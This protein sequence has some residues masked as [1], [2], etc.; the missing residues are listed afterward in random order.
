MSDLSGT[1][2]FSFDEFRKYLMHDLESLR[3]I[4]KEIATGGNFDSDLM[5]EQMDRVIQHCNVLNG[6][7]SATDESFNDLS[8]IG[9]RFL[10]D[11][12]EFD[13]TDTNT[14]GDL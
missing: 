7:Y 9:L 12:L 4:C 3:N 11:I 6:V 8:H 14:S 13:L 10:G 1:V 5:V 2:K